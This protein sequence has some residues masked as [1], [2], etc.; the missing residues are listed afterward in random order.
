TGGDL[1]KPMRTPADVFQVTSPRVCR[2]CG[3][4]LPPDVRW[5]LQCQ[6]RVID[7][8][9]RPRQLP[10]QVGAVVE[11]GP[12]YSR[13]RAGTTTFGPVGRILAT[14]LVLL[15]GPW[16]AVSAGTIVILPAWTAVAV[17]VLRQ[18]WKRE[19]V[20]VEFDDVP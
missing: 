1:V 8:S 14:L 18:I 10:A 19:R 13:W 5:C 12:T 3:A 16:G 15:L 2:A 6:A 17:I 20:S 9:P 11:P 7:F 4:T